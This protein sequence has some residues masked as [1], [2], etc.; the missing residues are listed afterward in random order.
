LE[1]LNKSD[2]DNLEELYYF[3]FSDDYKNKF[4]DE[5]KKLDISSYWEFKKLFDLIL[6]IKEL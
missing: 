2:Y 1:Q 4:I 6:K 3:K 5:C